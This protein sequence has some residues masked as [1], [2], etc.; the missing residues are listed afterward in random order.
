MKILNDNNLN[1][2]KAEIHEKIE[3]P[4][5]NNDN[6][7]EINKE[8]KEKSK[9]IWKTI[10]KETI[11]IKEKTIKGFFKIKQ[12]LEDRKS[13]SHNE[14]NK[15][16]ISNK[17][18]IKQSNGPNIEEINEK[19]EFQDLSI[20][21]ENDSNKNIKIVED[22][23]RNELKKEQLPEYINLN[24]KDNTVVQKSNKLNKNVQ[25]EK[26]QIKEYKTRSEKVAE[27][28]LKEQINSAENN[29]S[30]SYI[31]NN[32]HIEKKKEDEEFIRN[33]KLK[34]DYWKTQIHELYNY[35]LDLG[36][37][38][39]Y[40]NSKISYIRIKQTIHIYNLISRILIYLK[41]NLENKEILDLIN[42]L[43]LNLESK[44]F[45]EL[46]KTKN[47]FEKE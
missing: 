18:K 39:Y 21:E 46:L 41:E 5:K 36:K 10:K 24:K 37:I 11:T 13:I 22:H 44:D 15:K 4:K 45:Y 47:K 19:N 9:S 8:F 20:Y 25:E 30:V 3:E 6:E 2:Q 27:D 32:A 12:K 1:D 34:K 23:G 26:N 33:E 17:S 31:S 28:F 29:A 42:D 16:D 43:I 38:K 7:L 40:D 35:L 14:E